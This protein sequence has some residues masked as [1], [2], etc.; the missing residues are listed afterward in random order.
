MALVG[1]LLLGLLGTVVMVGV[2]AYSEGAVIVRVRTHHPAGED[3]NLF[4]P[5]APL[6]LAMKWIPK[7]SV[8][9]L[10]PEARQLLPAAIEAVQQLET[11]PDFVLAEVEQ[12]QK[13]VH[14]EKR[15]QKL[16]VEVDSPEKSVSI[17]F[18]LRTITR[19]LREVERAQDQLEVEYRSHCLP[20]G[21]LLTGR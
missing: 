21:R 2:L 11:T 20:S 17:E 7:A 19:A 12:I 10:P 4:L 1:K 14:I 3:R 8:P 9:Q 18:P 15:G 13:R 6:P 16:I 5:A